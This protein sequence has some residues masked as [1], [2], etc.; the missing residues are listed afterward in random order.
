MNFTVSRTLLF[1]FMAICLVGCM[2]QDPFGL[3]TRDIQGA[4]ELE[5]WEDGTTYYLIGPSHLP[6]NG[7]GAIEGTVG[8]LGWAEDIILVWQTDCGS[9]GGWRIIDTKKEK[10]SPITSQAKI[11]GD[12]VLSK[13][14]V[15]TA[16]DSWKKLN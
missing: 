8:R 7:W 1:A 3:R 4:Y 11:D 2:D 9:G 6:S 10:I 14:A 5:Q 12:P 15:F 13:I 16:A